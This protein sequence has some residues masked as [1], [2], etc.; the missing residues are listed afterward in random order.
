M[1]KR[2]ITLCVRCDMYRPHG[3]DDYICEQCR[4]ESDHWF[5]RD[6]HTVSFYVGD[7][8]RIGVNVECPHLRD[9][10]AA[11]Y[12]EP[13]YNGEVWQCLV[14]HEMAESGNPMELITDPYGGDYEIQGPNTPIEWYLNSSGPD[15]HGEYDCEFGWRIAE[16]FEN[17]APAQVTSDGNTAASSSSSTG[18]SPLQSFGT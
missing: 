12:L 13:T 9:P 16:D 10:E 5:K 1:S 7:G 18:T 6:G 15:R 17:T 14:S 3:E 8:G 4:F 2:A 11:C